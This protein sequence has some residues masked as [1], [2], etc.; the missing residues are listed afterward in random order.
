MSDTPKTDEQSWWNHSA[1]KIELCPA[2]FAR[3]LERERDEAKVNARKLSVALAD[4]IRF[5]DARR[6]ETQQAMDECNELRILVDGLLEINQ[7]L[8]DEHNLW[9]KEAER[10][11]AIK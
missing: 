3:K 6:D 4:S 7:E 1:G 5:S 8:Y 10:W 9:M 11:R 2:D